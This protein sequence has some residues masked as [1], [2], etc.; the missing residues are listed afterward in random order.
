MEGVVRVSEATVLSFL[1]EGL[2]Y[3]Y[4][5]RGALGILLFLCPVLHNLPLSCHL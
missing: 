5:L 1:V 4:N 2:V 3:S